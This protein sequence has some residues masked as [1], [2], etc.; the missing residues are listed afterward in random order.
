[1]FGR[2]LTGGLCRFFGYSNELRFLRGLFGSSTKVRV[3]SMLFDRVAG[4]EFW[5]LTV[6][7]ESGG[8]VRVD[9]GRSEAVRRG[10]CEPMP[11]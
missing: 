10:F 1:M 2:W 4:F 6:R 11:R 3:A 8:D 9:L 5:L 7:V